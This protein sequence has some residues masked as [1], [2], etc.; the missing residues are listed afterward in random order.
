MEISIFASCT[1]CVL[2]IATIYSNQNMGF[3]IVT[4]AIEDKLVEVPK[5][6]LNISFVMRELPVTDYFSCLYGLN[7]DLEQVKNP[8]QLYSTILGHQ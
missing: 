3:K 8:E 1:V 6:P 4:A 7:T 5:V 2:E